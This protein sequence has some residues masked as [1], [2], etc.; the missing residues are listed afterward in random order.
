MFKNASL[1]FALCM[2]WNDSSEKV[3]KVVYP[4]QNPVIKTSRAFGPR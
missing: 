4:P 1:Q 3:L 2:E